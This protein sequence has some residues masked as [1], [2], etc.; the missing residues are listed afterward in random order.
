MPCHIREIT[1]SRKVEGEEAL[2]ERSTIWDKIG[3]D[4]E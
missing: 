1:R 3:A 4:E 2:K